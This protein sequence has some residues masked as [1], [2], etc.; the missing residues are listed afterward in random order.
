MS[1][2]VRPSMKSIAA[3]AGSGA[4]VVI[5]GMAVATDQNPAA[6]KADSASVGATVTATTPSAVPAVTMARPTITG[7][8]PLFAG[9]APDSN[10]Q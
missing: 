10:P 7:P 6:A 8:A 2:R 4:L 3:L 1:L 5:G 9:E